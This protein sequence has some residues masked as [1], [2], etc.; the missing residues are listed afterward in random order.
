MVIC[1]PIYTAYSGLATQVQVG[2][3]EGLK[4]NSS[5]HCDELVSL[6]KAMLT[7]FIGSLKA[8]KIAAINRALLV[9]L[10]LPR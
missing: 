5:V 7:H 6:P 1:A 8:D 4:H 2:I 10:E 3:E 9:A